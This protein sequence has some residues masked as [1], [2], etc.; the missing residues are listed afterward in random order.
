VIDPTEA[1]RLR[2]GGRSTEALGAYARLL[3]S[4]PEPGLFAEAAEVAL[5]VDPALAETLARAG[6]QRAP[7]HAVAAHHLAEALAQQ[8][9]WSEALPLFRAA[10][11]ADGRLADLRH[12]DA[13][14][15]RAAAT[16]RPCPT[17]G[18]RDRTVR[19]VGNVTRKQ[20]VFNALDPVKVWVECRGCSLV[21]TPSVPSDAELAAYYAAQR[22]SPE[23]VAP[24]DGRQV[25]VDGL[26]WEAV[27]ERIER[28]LPGQGRMLEIGSGWGTFLACAAWRGWEV[29]GV[30][31]SPTAAAFAERTFGVET[32]C[33]AVPGGLPDERYDVIVAF[34]VIE[35]F[36]EPD[37]VL[38]ELRRR[39]RP[40]GL[41]VLT[42][43]DLDH[44][45]HRVL[46]AQDPMWSVPGHLVWYDRKT[47]DDALRFAGF[48]PESRWFSARHVGSTGI[49]ARSTDPA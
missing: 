41:L 7:N 16:D 46:G 23:G 49:V 43:P 27:L 1:R 29:T 32:R 10:V 33:A 36:A 11:A 3:E 48:R 24:P 9:R 34:E 40:D 6:L 2:D 21:Y 18:G 38:R 4:A 42:T 22:G 44:P 25:T 31:L 47:L 8:Q 14:P 19:W 17:C 5:R 12:R 35:H 37:R 39:L 30:E 13:R 20:T 26:A 15:W 28:A 45:A